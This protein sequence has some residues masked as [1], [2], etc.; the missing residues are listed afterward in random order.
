[1]EEHVE[2]EQDQEA[3]RRDDS[4]AHREERGHDQ[5][6]GHLRQH[7][8]AIGQ[9]QRLPEQDAAVLALVVQGA[10]AVEEHHEGQHDQGP[11]AS[12]QRAQVE[13]AAQFRHF[14]RR[15]GFGELVELDAIH[16]QLALLDAAAHAFAGD[17]GQGADDQEHAARDQRRPQEPSTVFPVFTLEK[18]FEGVHA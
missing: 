17:H 12:H 4:R 9:R 1:M 15:Q 13:P 7:R 3:D 8:L 10:Q 18:P 11:G 6:T 14:L 5:G 16:L 2:A